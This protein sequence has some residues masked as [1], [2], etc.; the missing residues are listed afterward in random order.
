MGC[1]VLPELLSAP[2]VVIKGNSS[3]T[4]SWSEWDETKDIG[5]PPVIGYIPYYKGKVGSSWI[6]GDLV[7]SGPR[8]FTAINLFPE[9][10]YLFRVAAVR[11]GGRGEGPKGPSLEVET[12]CDTPNIKPTNLQCLVQ[13]Y[14]QEVVNISWTVPGLSKIN[15]KTGIE[16][17]TIYV[18][19]SSGVQSHEVHDPDARWFNIEILEPGRYYR[20]EMTLSTTGGESSVSEESDMST[21]FLPVLPR[22]SGTPFFINVTSHSVTI[23]WLEWNSLTDVGTPFVVAYKPYF[24]LSN[25]S[26]W[27]NGSLVLFHEICEYTFDGLL[28]DKFYD[29]SVAAFRDG[30]GGEG[31]KSPF[32][33]IKV[34]KKDFCESSGIGQ[35]G[36]FTSAF[37]VV[38]ILLTTYILR[39]RKILKP[40]Q[41]HQGTSTSDL[42]QTKDQGTETSDFVDANIRKEE[43]SQKCSKTDNNRY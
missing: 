39:K 22:L 25:A 10:I 36:R 16:L 26:K 28:P 7:S 15:C 13:G 30:F 21:I 1:R 43:E 41:V 3:I 18:A 5:D 35:R 14:H 42:L 29:F 12:F 9:T 33:K 24:K 19:S 38:V 6:Q 2:T 27:I 8:Q 17:F 20:F 23:G 31:P 11:E 4:I 34:H 32:A 40:S 37:T